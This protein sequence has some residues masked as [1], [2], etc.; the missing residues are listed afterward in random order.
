MDSDE[1]DGEE[2]DEDDGE[3][4]DEDILADWPAETE[5]C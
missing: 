1:D 3:V 5:V 4:A 2:G